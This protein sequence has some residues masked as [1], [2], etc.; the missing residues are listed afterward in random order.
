M[1]EFEKE[2]PRAVVGL[3]SD[4]SFADVISRTC[5]E[6][7]SFGTLL[8][9]DVDDAKKAKNATDKKEMDKILGVSLR[10]SFGANYAANSCVSIM[11]EGR[12]FIK[13]EKI[14]K[15]GGQVYFDPTKSVFTDKNT[16]T[17]EPIKGAIF[18]SK[19]ENSICEIEVDFRGGQ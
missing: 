2:R 11:R 10:Q 13:A 15:V 19:S 14:E 6:V 18:M 8:V 16:A 4:S 17:S 9:V 12:V 1:R 5:S 3:K 7:V